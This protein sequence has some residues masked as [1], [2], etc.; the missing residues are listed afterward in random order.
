METDKIEIIFD[1]LVR[2]RAE[3]SLA[4]GQESR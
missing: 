4:V 2:V 1:S 3:I